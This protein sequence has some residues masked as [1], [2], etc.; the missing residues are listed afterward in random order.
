VKQG[1]ERKLGTKDRV[2]L[3]MILLCIHYS[4]ITAGPNSHDSCWNW[5]ARKGLWR[6]RRV[7]HLML[8]SEFLV[9]VT[10][11][12]TLMEVSSY[13]LTMKL[14]DIIC[15]GVASYKKWRFNPHDEN[16]ALLIMLKITLNLH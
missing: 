3:Q 5:V 14:L 1:L 13:E 11:R 7:G 8:S 15:A 6:E 2:N 10:L 9:W 16:I 4:E 12:I